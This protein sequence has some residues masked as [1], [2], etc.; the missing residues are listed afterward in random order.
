MGENSV[1]T[2]TSK[3]MARLERNSAWFGVDSFLLME[4]AGRRVAEEVSKRYTGSIAVVTGSGGKAGDGYV[5]A[6]HLNSMGYKVAVYYLVEPTLNENQAARSHWEITR[7]QTSIKLSRFQGEVEADIVVDALLGT[8]FRGKL[9]EPYRSAV[10]AINTSGARKV[11][12]DLPSGLEADSTV[13]SEEYV[14]CDLVV[15][16]HAPKPCLQ[17]LEGVEVVVANIG[18]PPEAELFAGPGDIE[19]NYPHRQPLMKKGDGGRVIVVGGSAKYT[20]AP[21][22]TVLGAFRGGADLVHLVAP[23]QVVEAARNQVPELICHEYRGDHLNL[24]S[25]EVMSDVIARA[26]CVAIGPGLG[27]D[28]EIAQ[29][30]RKIIEVCSER[31]IPLVVDADG[32]R[33][34][35]HLITEGW[36]PPRG[37]IYTPHAG[38]FEIL[39]GV[40]PS[41][42]LTSR[43][44]QVWELAQRLGSTVLLKGNCD[45]VASP[46]RV[47]LSAT[48]TPAMAVAGTGDVLTGLI[49]TIRAK[50]VDD[51]DS[52]LTGVCALG[53]A[54]S[55]ASKLMGE[56]IIER[57]IV[58]H[59]PEVLA[60]PQAA[61]ERVG[62]R[63]LP[64]EVLGDMSWVNLVTG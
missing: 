21:I 23:R 32:I 9:R 19:V 18:V 49:A 56:Q 10:H 15:T 48:G 41:V 53:F 57:D 64:D 26:R 55:L 2:V 11:C 50:G 29:S 16:M 39:A 17:A 12:I 52:A 14:K 40:K 36:T 35:G 30:V 5:A 25:L 62:V 8:G 46:L 7:R 44:K 43:V 13:L 51:F 4:N 22:L 59:L 28:A 42:D 61:A 58:Q 33:C 63:R 45:I 37:V 54:G 6:R 31:S 38:E 1:R 27:C 24:G 3:D 60:D 34:V 20:G 47:R